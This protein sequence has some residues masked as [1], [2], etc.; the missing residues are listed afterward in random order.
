LLPQAHLDDLSYRAR[1]N[2]WKQLDPVLTLVAEVD[3]TIVGFS[4]GA[5]SYGWTDTGQLRL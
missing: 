4:N 5:G 1:E 2:L 3:G